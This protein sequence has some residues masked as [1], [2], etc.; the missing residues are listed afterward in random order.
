MKPGIIVSL[1]SSAFLTI[2]F[3]NKVS[4]FNR[5][6][7]LSLKNNLKSVATWSFL[8]LPVCIFFAAAPAT[9]TSL[10]S[11]FMCTSSSAGSQWNLSSCISLRIL[12]RPFLILLSS[13]ALIN[14]ASFSTSAYAI[15]P[16]ISA[17]NNLLSMSIEAEKDCASSLMPES[18]L[19]PQS[20]FTFFPF[21]VIALI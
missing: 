14:L 18:N 19:P 3:C 8:D 12:A 16:L 6:A 1:F 13:D 5:S 9:F 2:D 10:D 7:I 21:L 15:D 20:G 17:S 4:K 11:I